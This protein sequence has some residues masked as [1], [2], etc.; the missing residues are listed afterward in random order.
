MKHAWL[1]GGLAIALVEARPA[2]ACSCAAQVSVV[3]ADGA[4]GVPLG[5]VVYLV[6]DELPNVEIHLRIAGGAT[7]VVA[8][9]EV[10]TRF[11]LLRPAQPLAANTQYSVELD[12]FGSVVQMTSF[13]T[14]SDGVVAPLAYGGITSF[15]PETMTYPIVD[16]SGGSCVS[17]CVEG[18]ATGHISRI[19]LGFAAAPAGTAVVAVRIL[20]GVTQAVVSET[21]L[22]DTTA[23]TAVMGFETCDVLA[24]VLAP[25]GGYCAQVVAYDAAGSAVGA[26]VTLCASAAVCKPAPSTKEECTPADTCDPEPPTAGGGGCAV[27][28]DSQGPVLAAGLLAL[29]SARRRRRRARCKIAG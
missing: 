13:T 29:V 11:A 17:S 18:A 12:S 27:A 14:A 1:V 8:T 20:D 16:G 23:T 24:P 15:A 2:A 9:T 22:A 28:R 7:D 10:H 19:R 6:S 25:G 21:A 26:D 5:G 4:Q 3:P